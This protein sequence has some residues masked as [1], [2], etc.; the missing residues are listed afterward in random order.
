MNLR[1]RLILSHTFIV[2][3]CLGIIVIVMSV[4][5]QGYR[6]RF[7]TARLDDMTMPIYVHF[8]SLAQ[9]VRHPGMK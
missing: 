9:S 7:V 4:I 6:D 5:M 3:L 1:L 2:L 8:R